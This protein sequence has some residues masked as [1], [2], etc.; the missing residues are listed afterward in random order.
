MR[1][2]EGWKKVLLG[3]DQPIRDAIASLD[4]QPIKLVLVVDS[5]GKL[6]GT[7]TDG[8]VRRGM[9]SG[10]TNSDPI[11]AIMNKKPLKAAPD[12]DPTELQ[13]KMRLKTIRQ[14]PIVD[15][16]DRILALEVY[17][18]PNATLARENW[19][20][21]MAGGL[22][23]R[24]G[25]LT[26]ET[27]KPLLAV[28]PK[29]ILE[30]I[31]ENF[32]A[33]GFRKFFI[34]VNYKAAMIEKHFGTGEK[35]GVE[36]RYLREKERMG[37]AGPLSLISEPLT[38]P[39]LVMNGDLLTK[40][41]FQQLLDFHEEQKS[42]ATMCVREFDLQVPYGV[43]RLE[44][45]QIT[46]IDEKPIHHFF[47]NAGIYLLEPSVLSLI[48]AEKYYDMP[49]LFECL[50]G[51]KSTTAAFPIREYWLDIGRV[52]DLERANDDFKIQFNG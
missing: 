29:P 12:Q 46:H 21:L 51:Q 14:V 23:S 45:N 3:P 2:T 11:R 50:I 41:N 47:I 48:P 26:E 44:K 25:A 10:R 31:L 32:I 43:V 20:V 28:G 52:N 17:D 27:P 37:T 8:D 1:E 39:L 49:S 6:L 9:L 30:T 5:D 34:A 13:K 4:A 19:V 35:W 16:N 33:Y 15:P 7:V 42:F 22:G 40:T 36:I 18:D 38:Q 24:L